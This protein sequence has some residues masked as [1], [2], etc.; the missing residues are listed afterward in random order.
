MGDQTMSDMYDIVKGLFDINQSNDKIQ[1][2]FIDDEND[3]ISFSSD[4]E[5]V[6]AFALVKSEGWKTFKINVQVDVE[7]DEDEENKANVA[8]VVPNVEAKVVVPKVEAK[9]VVPNTEAKAK[10][11][12]EVKIAINEL[13]TKPT[14]KKSALSSENS[15]PQKVPLRATSGGAYI[16]PDG[17]VEFG[18]GGEAVLLPDGQTVS[19]TLSYRGFPSVAA[20]GTLLTEGKWYYE[21]M[22][23][24]DGLMQI[25]WCDKKFEGNSNSGEG[26]GDDEHSIAY[27]GKRKLKWHNGRA[28]P[29][30]E[31][32]KAGDVVCCAADLDQGV[33]KFALNGKWNDR[34]TAFDSLIFHDGLMPAASFSKGEKLCFNFGSSAN[35]GFVHSPPDEE[36][37][38]VYIAQ[39]NVNTMEKMEQEQQEKKGKA[40]SAGKKTNEGKQ[41]GGGMFGNVPNENMQHPGGFNFT[42]PASG[43]FASGGFSFHNAPPPPYTRAT[44]NNNGEP[45]V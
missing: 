24:T 9:V 12:A 16:Y 23:L 37:L 4:R 15:K 21:A 20:A 26:V 40:K 36:Y 32:W 2:T 11:K 35:N 13:K 42:H 1:L 31:R 19:C 39:G 17:T 27:D 6:A 25:G 38:P 22:L 3:S 41:C 28:Q 29:F 8:V 5:L 44:E 10:A 34:S 18:M 14:A 7:D 33:V 45:T 30:G 43:L